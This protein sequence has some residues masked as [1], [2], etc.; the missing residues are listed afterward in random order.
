LPKQLALVAIVEGASV[1]ATGSTE[2]TVESTENVVCVTSPFTVFGG[3]MNKKNASEKK[4]NKLSFKREA[5]RRLTDAESKTVQGGVT[6]R[7]SCGRV[8]CPVVSG[9]TGPTTVRFP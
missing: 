3:I 7:D 1:S 9:D 4:T 2:R 6:C 5:I 8:T